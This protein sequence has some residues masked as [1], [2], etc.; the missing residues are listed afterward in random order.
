M[1]GLRMGEARQV[2]PV[3]LCLD[4]CTEE[5]RSQTYVS[6]SGV[7]HMSSDCI[8]KAGSFARSASLFHTVWTQFGKVVKSGQSGPGLAAMEGA[9]VIV[10]KRQT[11][12]HAGWHVEERRLRKHKEAE[13]DTRKASEAN[14]KEADASFKPDYIEEVDHCI[15]RL[16]QA[17]HEAALGNRAIIQG[18]I[19]KT[20]QRCQSVRSARLKAAEDTV[21]DS[22]P[23]KNL[24]ED[25]SLENRK[26]GLLSRRKPSSRPCGTRRTRMW[27]VISSAGKKE[28]AKGQPNGLRR[29]VS[30]L[31]W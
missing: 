29:S 16:Q 9:A 13:V 31:E 12:A 6:T 15:M 11:K 14:D 17:V 25:G 4:S 24:S 7:L 27:C 10:L 19:A 22:T 21:E 23:G 20:K 2:G 28:E 5:T 30:L 1:R 18:D 8:E 26:R 3:R